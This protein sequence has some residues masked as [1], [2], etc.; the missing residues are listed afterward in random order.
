MKV[1]SIDTLIRVPAGFA[2]CIKYESYHSGILDADFYV[3]PGL[4]LVKSDNY[5]GENYHHNPLQVKDFIE[6]RVFKQPPVFDSTYLSLDS[7]KNA[8][9]NDEDFGWV[10]LKDGSYTP[11]A[12]GSMGGD[13]TLVSD[14]TFMD[15]NNDGRKDA[16]GML[17]S[18]TGGSGCF[19]SMVIFLNR[20][21][22]PIFTDSYYIGDREGIDSIKFDG[23]RIHAFLKIHAPNDPM[24]CPSLSIEKDFDFINDR[25]KEI[26]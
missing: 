3:S 16:I 19:I 21:G 14:F 7:L 18:N 15:L 24:C 11:D 17:S 1:A 20:N 5:F 9:V 13:V 6:L 12:E 10:R 2:R 4:G 23:R 8:L 25:L 22:S 26:K